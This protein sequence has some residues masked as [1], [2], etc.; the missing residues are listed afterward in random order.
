MEVRRGGAGAV[1]HAT[2]GSAVEQLQLRGGFLQQEDR[3]AE[4]TQYRYHPSGRPHWTE[5]PA[6]YRRTTLWDGRGLLESETYGKGGGGD[7]RSYQYDG[8]GFVK[9]AIVNG[10]AWSY[11]AGPRGELHEV[12]QPG[13]VGEFHYGYDGLGRLASIL[14]PEGSVIPEQR[15]TWDH[16]DRPLTRTRGR[17]WV[18]TWAGGTGTTIDPNGSSRTVVYDGRGRPVEETYQPGSGIDS[19]VG[20]VQRAFGPDGQLLQALEGGAGATTTYGYDGSGL[21]KLIA[22]SG[23]GAGSIAYGYESGGLLSSVTSPS[24][25]VGYTYDGQARVQTVTSGRGTTTLT[26]EDGGA[27]LVSAS[28]GATT[29]CWRYDDRGRTTMVASMPPSTTCGSADVNTP[30]ARFDYGYDERNNRTSETYTSGGPAEVRSFGY[31]AADRLTGANEVGRGAVLYGLAPDGTRLCERTV[32]GDFGGPLGPG[33]CE[34]EDGFTSSSR[35][36]YQHDTA[37][38]LLGASDAVTGDSWS[39]QARQ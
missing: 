17:S 2:V 36:T 11:G 39:Y 26:W 23:L 25:Y 9:Q 16:L 15:F 5:D 30:L 31:D 32:A 22:R 14:P 10:V 29:E 4:T 35:I 38:G 27:R 13:G 20:S 21:L 12:V 33:G 19:G 37:G 34:G 6:G 7:T 24:G 1:R 3:G 18:T 8:G 28:D